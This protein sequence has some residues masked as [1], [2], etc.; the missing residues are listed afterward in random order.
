MLYITCI[1]AYYIFF[2]DYINSFENKLNFNKVIYPKNTI[3]KKLLEISEK[4]KDYVFIILTTR[5]MN[6]YNLH[7]FDS[8][9]I[10]ILNTEQ[11][12]NKTN[13]NNILNFTKRGF[14]IVDYSKENIIYNNDSFYLP[15]QVNKGE[16]YNFEKINDVCYIGHP[17]GNYRINLLNEIKKK[18]KIKIIGEQTDP[19]FKNMWGNKWGVERDNVAFRY[20]ILVNIHHDKNFL[21][22]EQMRI[23]RCIFNK[24]IV[25]SENGIN[26]DLLYLKKYIIFVKY[27]NLLDKVLEVLD[28]YEY[29]YNKL[30]NDFNIDDINEYYIEE[31]NKFKK[32]LNISYNYNENN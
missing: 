11:L 23:N 13:L 12:S 17:F 28:N 18:I 4:D 24:V 21:I 5:F 27:E 7:K 16:I 8:K 3:S 30:Y 10:F 9:K 31:I 32:N 14:S 1:Q 29:Y 15:Y 26:N 6:N 2:E 20:K 25:I 19:M 22:N